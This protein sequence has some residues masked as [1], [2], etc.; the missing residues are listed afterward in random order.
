M[1]CE[2]GVNPDIRTLGMKNW[3][4]AAMNRKE[5]QEI[6]KKAKAMMISNVYT[7]SF[8]YPKLNYNLIIMSNSCLIK[9]EVMVIYNDEFFFGLV[10]NYCYIY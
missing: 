6:R 8:T 1:R 5:W 2:Y 4:T 9:F 3:R 7:N 10:I